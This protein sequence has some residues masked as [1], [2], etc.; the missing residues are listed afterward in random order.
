MRFSDS[1][2]ALIRGVFYENDQLLKLMRKV[3]LPEIDPTAPLGQLVDLWM[4]I[5]LKDKDPE[6]AMIN[7]KARNQLIMHVEQQLLQ[8]QV[9]AN[10]KDETAEDKAAREAK[11]S[12]K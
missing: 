4:T 5:D 11:D 1:E 9:L 6:E 2:L 12:A 10:L 3:F 7:I 8:L